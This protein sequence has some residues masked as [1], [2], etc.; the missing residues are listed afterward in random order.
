[1]ICVTICYSLRGSSK[2]KED[3]GENESIV[4]LLL[5][6]EKGCIYASSTS[7]AN[8]LFWRYNPE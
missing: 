4:E 3:I 6:E 8:V 7:M 2:E 1:V 5:G